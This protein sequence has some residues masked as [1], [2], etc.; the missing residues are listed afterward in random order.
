MGDSISFTG[1]PG[2]GNGDFR[3]LALTSRGH[4]IGS[5]RWSEATRGEV[6]AAGAREIR[7]QQ[8]EERLQACLGR[9]GKSLAPAETNRKSARW[10]VAVAPELKATTQVSNRW[11]PERL[12]MGSPVAVSQ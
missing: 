7:E 5:G 11:I 1:S 4:L 3:P 6:E 9:A 12:H 2:V 8:W 10:K